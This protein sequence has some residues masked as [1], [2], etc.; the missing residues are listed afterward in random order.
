MIGASLLYVSD[1]DARRLL[2]P[3]KCLEVVEQVYRWHA[4]GQVEWPSPRMWRMNNAEFS[5]K[6]HVKGCLLPAIPV[7]GM[8]LVGYHVRPDGSGTADQDNM[9][10]VMLQD[11]QTGRPLGLVDEHWNYA[12]RT[13]ASALV[14]CK[15]L[16]RPESKVIGLVGVGNMG[17]TALLGLRELFQIESVRVT[18]RRPETR[19]AFATK[20]RSE[21]GLD[22]TA[23]HTPQEVVEGA[24]IVVSCTTANRN[25]VFP[26]WLK[27]G[28]VIA[29]LATNEIHDDVYREMDKIV[30]DDWEQNRSLTDIKRLVDTGILTP[31]RIYADIAGIVSGARPGR[32]SDDERILVRT[33][34]LVTQDVALA[35]FVYQEATKNGMGTRLA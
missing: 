17:Y 5:A 9:R 4:S 3:K 6:Y 16:A 33:E 26:G 7:F 30:F 22:V 13:T 35:Y 12:L 14:A 25:L 1:E 8:R 27:P 29:S 23:V 11:P 19:A 18:S 15:Y 2:T 20:M 34:G 10:Y 28:S 32:E 31:D 21:T 24:D